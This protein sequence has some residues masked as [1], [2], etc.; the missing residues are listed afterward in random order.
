MTKRF[1][2]H[3]I[4]KKVYKGFFFAVKMP[5]THFLPLFPFV[6][7]RNKAEKHANTKLISF[8]LQSKVTSS[9]AL[10]LQRPIFRAQHLSCW[11]D[12]YLWGYILQWSLF[13]RLL[14]AEN[15]AAQKQTTSPHQ[16]DAIISISVFRCGIWNFIL[17]PPK[18]NYPNTRVSMKPQVI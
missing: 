6:P 11:N 7:G 3:P 13:L 8:L 4:K 17:L 12:A 2:N 10:E 14:K 16:E 1:Y 9:S 5:L 18:S 15:K